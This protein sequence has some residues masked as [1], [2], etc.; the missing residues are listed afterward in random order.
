HQTSEPQPLRAMLAR[1]SDDGHGAATSSQRKCRLP[2]FE[3][4]PSLSLP[5]VECCQAD[6]CTKAAA[7]RER[8]PL[9]DLGHQ[10]GSDDIGVAASIVRAAINR[11]RLPAWATA[12]RSYLELRRR[13]SALTYC[14]II[15]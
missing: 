10:R 9:S 14:Y 13:R 8:L 7:G 2:C 11:F 15:T 12:R 5:P 1:T 6:P 3:M 4:L